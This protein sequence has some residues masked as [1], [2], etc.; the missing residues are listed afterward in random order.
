VKLRFTNSFNSSFN[1]SF[2]NSFNYSFL[3]T[4]ALL[5]VWC[6]V[7][8]RTQTTTPPVSDLEDARR[9]SR[10]SHATS[11]IPYNNFFDIAEEPRT[12]F[13]TFMNKKVKPALDKV[14]TEGYEIRG[15]EAV[16]LAYNLSFTKVQNKVDRLWGGVAGVGAI[17]EKLKGQT[18]TMDSLPALVARAGGTSDRY[19]IATFLGFANGGGASVKFAKD[20]FAYNV[21]YAVN[22]KKSGRSYGTGPG[23]GAN[24]ASDKDYLTALEA[25][26]KESKDNQEAFYK[27]MFLAL[28]NTDTSQYD[29]VTAE[30]Q[31]VLT[32][33][34]AVYIAEEARNL[35]GLNDL[36]KIRPYWEAALLEVTM[37]AAFHSNQPA[38]KLFYTNTVEN[39][40]VSFTDTVNNQEPCAK[41]GTTFRSRKAGLKDYWQF[42]RN[43]NDPKNCK[44][45][46]INITKKEFRA[47]GKAITK[48]MFSKN[49]TTYNAVFKAMGSPSR[50][51]DNM[52]EALSYYLM[53]G[54][55]PA[56]LPAEKVTEITDAWIKWLAYTR[57]NAEAISSWID[58]SGTNAFFTAG[59]TEKEDTDHQGFDQLYEEDE[60]LRK[61]LGQ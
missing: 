1:N 54:S 14:A 43:V 59:S 60:A 27:N 11:Y 56:V 50:S 35:M 13:L 7:S 33:F 46:G 24:D 29:D 36:S 15:Q 26:T 61:A 51:K 18:V 42:S 41:P 17:A 58:A 44:R 48:Y 31:G 22:E 47:L 20:N 19:G 30:G 28:L 25:Y 32:D 21:H 6:L 10:P 8:C 2:N 45:S 3:T 23:R 9:V 37:L 39:S 16:Q 55:T 12:T 49:K 34:L 4:A 38:L 52:Y 57:D 5:G 40:T 53:N